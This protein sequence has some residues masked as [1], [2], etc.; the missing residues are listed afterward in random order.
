MSSNH[1]DRAVIADGYVDGT[2]M[3]MP[4]VKEELGSSEVQSFQTGTE[5]QSGPSI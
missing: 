1:K 5:R 4:S 2:Y 3:L